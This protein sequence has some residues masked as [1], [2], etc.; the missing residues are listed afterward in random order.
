MPMANPFPT[1]YEQSAE[2]LPKLR[3]GDMHLTLGFRGHEYADE[4]IPITK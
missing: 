3:Q 4:F 1:E 2:R